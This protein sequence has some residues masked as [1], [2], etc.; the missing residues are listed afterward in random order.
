MSRTLKST[1]L[2]V[3][4]PSFSSPFSLKTYA[5]PHSTLSFKPQKSRAAHTNIS[6]KSP[7]YS[8]KRFT[9]PQNMLDNTSCSSSSTRQNRWTL[10]G[11]TA[12]VTGGTR[13]IGYLS[14][15][16]WFYFKKN[17]NVNLNTIVF[18]F[19]F[20]GE[21]L[22]RN[23]WVLEQECTRVVGMEVSLISA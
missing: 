7:L 14:I 3:S 2:L 10:H 9:S 13:G 12:L 20:L 11:K 19:C 6:N 4:S 18:F 17:Y 1:P 15:Y 5:A 16:I 23:W 21:Q 22:W 8:T